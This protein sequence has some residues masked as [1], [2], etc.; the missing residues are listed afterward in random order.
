MGGIG[1]RVEMGA[2]VGGEGRGAVEELRCIDRL[3]IPFRPSGM[4]R[5]VELEAP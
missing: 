5:C 4:A 2:E 3:E 1:F